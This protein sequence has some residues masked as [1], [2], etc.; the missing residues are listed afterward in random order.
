MPFGHTLRM[1]NE[2]TLPGGFALEAPPRRGEKG[3]Y[4]GHSGLGETDEKPFYRLSKV[5][6]GSIKCATN[7]SLLAS[8]LLPLL[9]K[10]LN[11]TIHVGKSQ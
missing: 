1:G 7:L 5:V 4:L 10:R 9:L 3:M 6:G 2:M 8:C 11:R